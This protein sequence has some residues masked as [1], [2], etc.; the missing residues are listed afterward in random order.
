MKRNMGNGMTGSH[1][2]HGQPHE[3]YRS[4][5]VMR[6]RINEYFDYCDLNKKHYTVPDLA[7]HLGFR[8][9][10]LMNYQYGGNYPDFQRVIDYALQRIEAYTVEKLFAT[11]GST[12]GIEFLMQNTANYANKSDVSS[13]QELEITERQRIQQLPDSEV[14]GRLLHILPKIQSVIEGEVAR[15]KEG[16]R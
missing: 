3:A 8:T 14:K 12:K 13:K 11:K 5:A 15:Q 7:L 2:K 4:A 16:S 6:R 1:F 9:R 10:V